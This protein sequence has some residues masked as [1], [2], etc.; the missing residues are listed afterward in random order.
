MSFNR[1]VKLFQKSYKFHYLEYVI[2]YSPIPHTMSQPSELT[3]LSVVES[4]LLSEVE[5]ITFV[6]G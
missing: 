3:L 6:I 4:K 5:E 1:T 2:I